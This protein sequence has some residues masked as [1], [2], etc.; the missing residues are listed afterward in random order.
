MKTISKSVLIVEDEPYQAEMLSGIIQ[1]LRPNYSIDSCIEDVDSAV[2][3]FESSDPDLIFMDIE[4]GDRLCF[5]IFDHIEIS[6]PVIYCTSHDE[7]ALEAFY[8][9]GIHFLT[10]PTT[11]S[12]VHDG[13]EKYELLESRLGQ[14]Q[15]A[16]NYFPPTNNKFLLNVGKFTIPIDINLI[17]YAYLKDK[18]VFIVMKDEKVYTSDITLDDL[19][20][21]L[22]PITF[23][24]INRQF[25]VHIDM[26]DKFCSLEGGRIE[27][28]LKGDPKNPQHVSYK[29]RKSFLNWINGLMS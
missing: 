5:E 4:L 14:I 26:I 23:F 9:N 24:R 11:E 15:T 8:K 27:V 19:G 3:Y 2:Q 18:I 13:L 7:F 16:R 29:R 21:Q 6:A 1:S 25:I 10:K 17:K 20:H 28:S 12:R 22:N